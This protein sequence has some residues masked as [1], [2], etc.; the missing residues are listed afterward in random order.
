MQ[1]RC[2]L[3]ERD[4]SPSWRDSV[5]INQDLT[6]NGAR[7]VMEVNVLHFAGPEFM[8]VIKLADPDKE[9]KCVQTYTGVGLPSL[10]EQSERRNKR[11]E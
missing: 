6:W 5:C 9:M 2:D 10:P 3:F 7:D 11:P 4:H 1:G 8:K